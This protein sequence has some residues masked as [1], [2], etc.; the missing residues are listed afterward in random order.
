MTTYEVCI[1]TKFYR[2]VP[3]VAETRAEA[4]TKAFELMADGLDPCEEADIERFVF[5]EE[6]EA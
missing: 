5:V 3:V 2:T 1:I 4:R 6:K